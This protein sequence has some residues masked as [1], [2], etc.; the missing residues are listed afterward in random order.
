TGGPGSDAELDGTSWLTFDVDGRW[1]PVTTQTVMFGLH[2]D[3]YLLDSPKYAMT[4]WLSDSTTALQTLSKGQ[5]H[6]WAVWAQDVWAITPQTKLTL[7]G[8]YEWWRAE[9]GL[10]FSAA[11][12]LNTQQPEVSDEAFSPKAV[13]AWSPQSSVIG[14]GWTFKGSVGVANRFPTVSE[15]YQAVT[16]GVVLSV[17]N[18]NLK[19]ERALSSELSVERDWT[20]G[21]LRVS[22]FDERVHNALISQTGTLNGS[23]VS[24]VQNVERTRSTGVEVVGDQKDVLV[25]GLEISGWVTYLDAQTL[26]DPVLPAAEGKRLPQL[27]RWRGAM[28]ATYSPTERLALTLAAR[29]SDRM[30][31]TIDNSDHYANTYQGFD[32]FFVV[33]A[34][35]RYRINDHLA[36]GAGV[37]NLNDRKYILFHPFP[38]R[39]AL[40]D[41]KYTY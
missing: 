28:V 22:L 17:P 14:D 8:R 25:K 7:G 1:R 4:N 26:K 13:A 23:A 16:T 35:A 6:T 20:G 38:Q 3:S 31:A 32:A 19:P 5:T 39:T 41:L 11:P 30:F 9:K 21:S 27:A 29:Y 2:E 18:P 36:I 15:L 40:I 10:N 12:A 33:D 37:D 34:H 24:F